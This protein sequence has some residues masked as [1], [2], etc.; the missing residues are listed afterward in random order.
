MGAYAI[1]NKDGQVINAI[2][3]DRQD[4]PDFD[5]GKA[6]GNQAILIEEGVAAGPGF[7]YADGKFLAPALTAEEVEQQ[8]QRAISSNISLK[9]SLMA[10]AT[11][12]R[13]TLQDAV[14]LDEATEEEAAALPLW[15]KYRV[16]LSRIDANTDQAIKWPEKP[17]L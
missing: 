3:W 4:Q 13:D 10:E 1:V 2:A 7:T 15:K 5:Y 8:K 12:R 6:D 9:E 14:D 16:I 11:Q 17:S